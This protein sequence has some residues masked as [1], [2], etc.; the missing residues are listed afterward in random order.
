MDCTI[1]GKPVI[2]RPTA[3]ERA[4]KDVTGKSAKY[5]TR[6]FPTHATCALAKRRDGVSDLIARLGR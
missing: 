1:C 5:Y 4:A 6:L 2:L 3:K